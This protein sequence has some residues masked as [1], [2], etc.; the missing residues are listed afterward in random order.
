MKKWLVAALI[1]NCL[2]GN[3]LPAAEF[4]VSTGGDDRN[5]G[6]RDRPFLTLERARDAIRVQ[7][8]Q[9]GL[10]A[11]GANVWVG[12]GAYQRG[13]AF[14]LGPEDSGAPDAPVVYRSLEGETARLFGGKV[15][16]GFKPAADPAVL[17]RLEEKARGHVL[18]S[19][20][21]AQ[22]IQDFGQLRSRGFGR[23]NAPAHLE[24][25]FQGKPMELARWPNDGFTKIA[26]PGEVNPAGDGHG[27]KIGRLEGGFHYDGDRP[28]LWKDPENIWSHGYWAWDWANSYEQITSIDL[29][30][31]L[32]KTRAHHG[33][34]GFRAGQRVYFLNALIDSQNGWT[35]DLKFLGYNFGVVTFRAP[36][37]K[38][39]MRRPVHGERYNLCRFGCPQ[40][41]DQHCC[42]R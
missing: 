4:F 22:G 8:K 2:S 26:A 23:P 30:K 18:E 9:G 33:L 28:R 25:F 35:S 36:E 1:S 42:C 32:I 5:P 10:P 13:R 21:R 3:L 39:P 16:S 7:K 38:S 6:T 34:Y 11:G 19:D 24:M 15:V 20:L 41:T 12:G 37:V 27:G 14:E 29:E 31:R 40:N 17:E